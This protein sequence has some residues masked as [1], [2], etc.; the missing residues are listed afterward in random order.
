MPDTVLASLETNH[1][2]PTPGIQA[3]TK[4]NLTTYIKKKPL[5]ANMFNKIGTISITTHSAFCLTTCIYAP[6]IM[7][8]YLLFYYDSLD[9]STCSTSMCCP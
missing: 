1:L 4:P 2:E 6:S 3:S 5:L 7:F 9:F 8:Y